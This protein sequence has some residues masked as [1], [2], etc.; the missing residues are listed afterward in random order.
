[1][2]ANTGRPHSRW[3]FLSHAATTI[4]VVTSIL[5]GTTVALAAHVAIAPA[6][7]FS[8]LL[9]VAGALALAATMLRQQ[10][11]AWTRADAHVESLFPSS[12]DGGG[13]R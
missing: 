7:G 4:L 9:G 6:L 13:L 12:S 1:M 8:A 5:A 3:H 2:G 10:A 11:R